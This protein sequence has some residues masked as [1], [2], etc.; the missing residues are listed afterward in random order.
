MVVR[1]HGGWTQAYRAQTG[2]ATTPTYARQNP[3]AYYRTINVLKK[4]ILSRLVLWKHLVLATAT[5]T[6]ILTNSPSLNFP[7]KLKISF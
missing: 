4:Q 6:Y 3:V 1:V 5:W 7:I 2:P